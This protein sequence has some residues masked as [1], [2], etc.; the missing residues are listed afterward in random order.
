MPK[1]F[2]RNYMAKDIVYNRSKSFIT[3]HSPIKTKYSHQ[4]CQSQFS[5]QKIWIHQII[6]FTTKRD[7]L[8]LRVETIMFSLRHLSS[9]SCNVDV[10]S[11]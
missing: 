1:N 2:F 7:R 9:T 8:M 4:K 6:T 5:D 3:F 10:L 11:K